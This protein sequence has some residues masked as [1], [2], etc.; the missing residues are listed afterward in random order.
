MQKS[1][2]SI[3]G[4][5]AAVVGLAAPAGIMSKA[6]PALPAKTARKV[7]PKAR[8]SGSKLDYMVKKGTVGLIHP[9]GP[10]GIPTLPKRGMSAKRA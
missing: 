1:R 9:L 4:S 8:T 10:Y 5:L 6:S 3:L 2:I 7:K